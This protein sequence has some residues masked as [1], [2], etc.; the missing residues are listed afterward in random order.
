MKK[1][2]FLILCSILLLQKGN[3]Q[4]IIHGTDATR[5][6]VYNG[7]SSTLYKVQAYEVWIAEPDSGTT[8]GTGIISSVDL[9]LIPL[10]TYP[11]GDDPNG[12]SVGDLYIACWEVKT[13]YY[14]H[15]D[16]GPLY[17]FETAPGVTT[18]KCMN[19]NS[20]ACSFKY[21]GIIY[22]SSNGYF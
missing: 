20:N 21:A 5:F 7:S 8:T 10:T 22:Y 11:M 14:G 2:L 13:G 9:S 15:G 17:Y 1:N 3:S 4:M 18:Q 16:C 12:G 6:Y 19:S